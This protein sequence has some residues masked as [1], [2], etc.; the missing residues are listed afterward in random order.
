MGN[1]PS[2]ATSINGERYRMSDLETPNAADYTPVSGS[3][4]ERG[5]LESSASLEEPALLQSQQHHGWKKF[6]HWAKGPTPVRPYRIN[7]ICERIQTAPARYFSRILRHRGG[8]KKV[9]ALLVYLVWAVLFTLIL[10]GSSLS[11]DIPGYGRPFKL[12]CTTRLWAGTNYC[13]LNGLKCLP[14]NEHSFAFS[15]PANCRQVKVLNPYTIGA[16]E[17]NYKPMVV[18]GPSQPRS[19][20]AQWIYRGDSFLCGAA[21]HAGIIRDERGGCGIVS[22][23]G[24]KSDYQASE[25]N[26]IS[27]IG[28]NSSFPLSFGFIEGDNRASRALRSCSDP[29]WKLL[30]LSVIFT[31]LISAFTSSPAAFFIPVCIIVYFQVF[32]ASDPPPFPDY[33]SGLS[34]ASARLLPA[35]FVGLFIYKYCVRYSLRGLNAPIEKTF[36][37]LGACWVGALSNY[38]LDEIPIQRLTPHDIQQ[39]PGAIPALILIVLIILGIA[40]MQAWAFRIEGRLPRYLGI[41][42][43]LCGSLLLL[44]AIPRL[45]LRLHHYILSLLLLPGTALQ[46]RPS[47]LYQGFLVGLFINGVARWGFDSILQTSAALLDDGKQ[48]SPLP[49]ILSPV[50]TS[51]NITFTW[52]SLATSYAGLS[53][54]VNDVQRHVG[55]ANTSS[56]TW[57]R[58]A[59]QSPEYFRF[60]Y[61]KYLPLG[62]LSVGDYTKAGIWETDGSWKPIQPGP[63]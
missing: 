60:A 62:D 44:L 48:G 40:L 6:V 57:T 12:K 20:H 39:Q 19:E 55:L 63:T 15:C 50:I 9:I 5:S 42:G 32:L 28:F 43:I 46:T 45:K 51:N 22:R 7:P 56:F 41:Y 26:G 30:G 33:D 14:F 35:A 53:I 10:S 34:F 17:I 27:S 4:L 2:K 25:R 58:H 8:W 59:S 29:R 38:T 31:V 1:G 47:L 54:L 36:L 52:E 61:V 21:L 37:W 18:G 49:Q 23:L 16:E 11:I 24:E 13:G 3:S